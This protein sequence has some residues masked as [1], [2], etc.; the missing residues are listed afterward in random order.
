MC[1]GIILKNQRKEKISVGTEIKIHKKEARLSFI[2]FS[3][4]ENG[5]K[6]VPQIRAN[7]KIK[8]GLEKF[9]LR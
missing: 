3:T 7:N 6:K 4:E 2:F 1:G 9:T 5:I 8:K